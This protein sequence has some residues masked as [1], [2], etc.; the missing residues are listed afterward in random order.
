[1]TPIRTTNNCNI[2]SRHHNTFLL[3]LNVYLLIICTRDEQAEEVR[4]I[5]A[6]HPGDFGKIYHLVKGDLYRKSFQETGNTQN[7][8]WSCGESLSLFQL[9]HS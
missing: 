9:K 3:Y 5:E 6:K 1:M 4:D 2:L 7:S 8:V